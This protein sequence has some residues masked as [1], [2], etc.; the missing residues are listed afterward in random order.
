MIYYTANFS[1]FSNLMKLLA[2]LCWWLFSSR[3]FMRIFFIFSINEIK[4]V[5]MIKSW[6]F[7]NFFAHFLTFQK[8]I[9]LVVFKV[10]TKNAGA[11]SIFLIIDRRYVDFRQINKVNVFK[12]SS[13]FSWFN[14]F[15]KKNHHHTRIR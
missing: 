4:C 11:V 10:W 3:V 6:I 9:L 2:K 12:K 1:L 7:H 8:G 5:I 15:K 14:N 13:Q